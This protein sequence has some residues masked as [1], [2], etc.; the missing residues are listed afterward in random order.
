MKLTV[1]Q[2]RIGAEMTQERVAKALGIHPQTYAKL[3]KH[4]EDMSIGMAYNF[5]KTVGV[6]F[7]DVIFLDCNLN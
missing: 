3:E 6:D 5:A 7:S 2:A 1:K 4:P